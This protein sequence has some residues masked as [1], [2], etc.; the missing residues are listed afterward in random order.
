MP[1]KTNSTYFKRHYHGR[2]PEY[3]SEDTDYQR[4]LYWPEWL[5]KP[6]VKINNDEGTWG[7]SIYW[8]DNIVSSLGG[9]VKRSFAVDA[10]H[11][12]RQRIMREIIRN[13]D[14][15]FDMRIKRFRWHGIQEL[16]SN[17]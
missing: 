16:D 9:F 10:S 12:D 3:P 1:R 7:Y 5:I 6:D 4:T 17:H 15:S 8:K 2:S 11:W 14:Y 13:G